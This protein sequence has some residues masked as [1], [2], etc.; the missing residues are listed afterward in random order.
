M[1]HGTMKVAL[2]TGGAGGIGQ[3]ICSA[4][5]RDGYALVIFDL[6]AV[7]IASDGCDISFALDVSDAV[8]VDQAVNHALSRL[9]RIDVLINNAGINQKTP[10]DRL[11]AAEWD[12]VLAVNLTSI[13]RCVHAV[14][15]AMRRN[16]GG[17][18]VNIASVSGLLSIP[19]R[20]AYTAAKHGVI[21]MTRALAG[22]L[23]ADNIRVNAIAPGMI[24][25]PMTNR[26]LC[27]PATRAAVLRSIPLGRIGRPE[28]VAEAV[29]F[30]ASD[31]ASYISGACLSID[32]AFSAEKTFAP[33]NGHFAP[34]T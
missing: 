16:G 26:Y 9:G 7:E 31:R 23:A 14:F 1:I 6:A 34:G 17:V 29:A 25:T 8:A 27:D 15:P 18:I 32:G 30:L 12:K 19:G 20:S 2:V 4:L 10:S 24:E 28:D 11:D 33:L 13:H 3:A 5:R 21:G 22:D